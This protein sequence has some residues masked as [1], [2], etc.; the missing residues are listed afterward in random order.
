EPAEVARFSQT[1]QQHKP[2]IFYWW[3]PQYLNNNL[4]LAEVKLPARFKGCQDDASAGGIVKQYRC[5]YATYPL[6]KLI[7]KKFAT[8]GSRTRAAR[9]ATPRTSSSP[10]TTRRR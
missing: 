6:E 4:D 1:I 8:S 9:R 10:S 7:S 5:A 3:T 2:V